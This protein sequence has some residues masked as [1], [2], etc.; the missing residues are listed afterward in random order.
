MKWGER[1]GEGTLF[2]FLSSGPDLLDKREHVLVW[3]SKLSSHRKQ[4]SMEDAII[5]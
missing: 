2:V 5:M 3:T 1:G 4:S